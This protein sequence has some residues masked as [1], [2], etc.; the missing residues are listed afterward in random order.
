[1]NKEVINK[2]KDLFLKKSKTTEAEWN[3]TSKLN[4]YSTDE[5]PGCNKGWFTYTVDSNDKIFY[6]G[7]LFYSK[8]DKINT[9][10]A[11]VYLKQFAKRKQCNKIVFR[12]YRNN[13]IWQRRFKDMKINSW[14]MEV[15]L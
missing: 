8:N 7:S 2:Y 3:I 10:N 13:K 5:F 9:D 11:F 1:M 14:I 6:I 4:S 12:T 15:N